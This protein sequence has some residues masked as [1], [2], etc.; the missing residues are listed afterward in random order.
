MQYSIVLSPLRMPGGSA[1]SLVA[2][3]EGSTTTLFCFEPV[4]SGCWWLPALWD[5]RNCFGSSALLS[6][7][8]VPL[9][10]EIIDHICS[11]ATG[12]KQ[13]SNLSFPR[14][15]L[16]PPQ[17][18]RRENHHRPSQNVLKGRRDC[19]ERRRGRTRVTPTNR[20]LRRR[21]GKSQVPI[22]PLGSKPTCLSS[23]DWWRKSSLCHPFQ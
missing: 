19:G 21:S 3:L 9:L 23:S 8:L 20:I 4:E 5:G 6:S 11:G 2:L 10:D 15:P 7:E 14:Y 16:H 18:F 12:R 22:V 17:C 13:V 1:F